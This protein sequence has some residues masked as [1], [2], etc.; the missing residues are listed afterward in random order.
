MNRNLILQFIQ[1]E[2]GGWNK[3][4]LTLLVKH[5]KI[6]SYFHQQNNNTLTDIFLWRCSLVKETILF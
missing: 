5:S 3:K 2:V 1:R 4:Y 6:K